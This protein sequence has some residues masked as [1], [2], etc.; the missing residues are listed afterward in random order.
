[1]R[2]RFLIILGLLSLT[3]ACAHSKST[4]RGTAGARVKSAEQ[5]PQAEYHDETRRFLRMSIDNP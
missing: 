2:I 3:V 1:M 4:T 5:V